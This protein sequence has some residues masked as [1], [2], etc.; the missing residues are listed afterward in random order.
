MDVANE[1]ALRAIR[2]HHATLQEGLAQ[3]AEALLATATAGFRVEEARFALLRYLDDE[4]L[5]HA[6]AEETTLYRRGEEIPDLKLL[7]MAMMGEH[8][9]LHALTRALGEPLPPVRAAALGQ[10]IVDLFTLHAA[11]END[12][13]LPRLVEE[14]GVSIRDLL[15]E[16]HRELE[17]A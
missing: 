4:I 12:L 5:P 11:K 8:E 10:A 9:H 7:L 14:P 16:M 1:S 2:T 15:G 17:G 3:R 6:Q 13:L